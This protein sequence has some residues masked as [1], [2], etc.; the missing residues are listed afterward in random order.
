MKLKLKKY[1]E[2]LF[3]L[4]IFF[5]PLEGGFR[6]IPNIILIALV[7]LFILTIKKSDFKAFKNKIF[8]FF[9]VFLTY[10]ILNFIINQ[11]LADNLFIIEKLLVI[12]AVYILY[13]PIK[14]D[15]KLKISFVLGVFVSL[16]FSLISIVLYILKSGDFLFSV[17]NQIN[18]V[19]VT[20]RV[21]IAFTAV[22]SFVFSL[23]L[24]KHV[25]KK[26]K[27]L[28]L[29]N[30][31]IIIAFILMISARMALLSIVLI[32]LYHLVFLKN[33]KLILIGFIV[34]SI[35]LSITF[36]LNENLQNRFLYKDKKSSFIENFKKWEPRVAIWNCANILYHEKTTSDQLFGYGSFETTKDKLLECYSETIEDKTKMNWFLEIRYNTHNQFLDLLLSIGVLGMI[37][38]LIPVILIFVKNKNNKTNTSLI[39]A[40][41]LLCFVENCLHRQIGAYLFA[42]IF[43]LVSRNFREVILINKQNKE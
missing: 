14:I 26:Y 34:S 16:C 41:L 17:G 15:K 5:L 3:C 20:E 31:L 7:P 18:E 19:L 4:L 39:L 23:D 37:L 11:N 36:F 28:L 40:F 6:A 12:V 30:I 13:I 29:I 43:T 9:L 42:L 1:Y 38:F 35:F 33:F 32:S 24:L 27:T 8:I 2:F 22:I 25:I 10:V 21:Y